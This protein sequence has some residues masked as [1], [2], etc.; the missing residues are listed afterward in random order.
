MSGQGGDILSSIS[1]Y[2][3]Y[4][5]IFMGWDGGITNTYVGVINIDRC[6]NRNV[7]GDV[8]EILIFTI[9]THCHHI[10][11][12]ALPTKA[13]ILCLDSLSVIVASGIFGP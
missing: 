12:S 10:Q 2:A 1:L 5:F 4:L 7:G 11:Y 13:R 6:P 9:Y 3:V 8:L